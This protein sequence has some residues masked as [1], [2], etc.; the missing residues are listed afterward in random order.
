MI[1]SI[2]NRKRLLSI[3]HAKAKEAIETL[4]D[5]TRVDLQE[6]WGEVVKH[7]YDTGQFCMKFSQIEDQYMVQRLTTKHLVLI[8]ESSFGA[9]VFS[10]LH[11]GNA[12]KEGSSSYVVKS[13]T[14]FLYL[15][16]G[17]TFMLVYKLFAVIH[18]YKMIDYVLEFYYVTCYR[19]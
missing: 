13:F 18:V 9:N 10:T 17:C 12:P 7:C 16:F 8:S 5:H 19:S 15:F 14:V 11:A 3:H 2:G 1:A 6:K 4:K